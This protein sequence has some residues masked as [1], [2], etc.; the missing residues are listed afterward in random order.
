KG[1]HTGTLGR[2]GALSFNGNKVI[3][4]GGG[5]MILCQNQEDGFRAKHITTTAKV[6][7]PYEF[8]HDEAGFN[9]R[10]P[11]LNAALGCAQI[12]QLEAKLASKR[13]IAER[14]LE[15]FKNT[16]YC[17]VVEPEYAQSNYWL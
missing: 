7:H 6:P 12:E 8:Y 11:N 1:K 3:T 14:Y 5:G 17:F 9:Y 10:M 16:D 2:F 13:L 4:T 15:F